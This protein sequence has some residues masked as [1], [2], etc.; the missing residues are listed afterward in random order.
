MSENMPRHAVVRTDAGGAFPPPGRGVR[1][2]LSGRVHVSLMRSIRGEMRKLLSLRSTWIMLLL[3]FLA[4]PAG[5]LVLAFMMKLTNGT[6]MPAGQAPG[7]SAS[8][9][10]SAIGSLYQVSAIIVAILGVMSVTADYTSS[11]I[12]S[13]L[14]ANPHR[15]MVLAG[16]GVCVAL[17]TWVASQLSVL[18]SWACVQAVLSSEQ[19][20]P[21]EA[22]MSRL[23][24]VII[25]GTPAMLTLFAVMAVG[26]GALCR[27]TLGGVLVVFAVVM[28]IPTFLDIISGFQRYFSWVA[29]LSRAFPMSLI[30]SFLDAN[31][32]M[33]EQDMA[34]DP[35]WW[36]CGLLMV[37][38]TAAFYII[39]HIVMKV[40][41]IK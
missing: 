5:G 9:Y 30:A 31:P 3:D 17:V 28:F 26:I 38:W 23:P 6:D 27:S 11:S 33:P 21:L 12:D 34:F 22:S 19:V 41:D 29:P 25:L 8:A 10:W 2:G 32:P 1:G 13:T 18:V 14:T 16:K 36:Q 20:G 37:A 7:L 35:Q 4:L 39:G 40:A 24:W 15:G